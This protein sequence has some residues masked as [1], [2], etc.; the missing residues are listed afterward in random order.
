MVHFSAPRAAAVTRLNSPNSPN[1]S[2]TPSTSDRPD[3]PAPSAPKPVGIESDRPSTEQQAIR[4][5]LEGLVQGLGVR[6]AV[7]RLAHEQ[8]LTGCV[9]NDPR[10]VVVDV[11]GATS[12]VSRF[13]AELQDRL[14][15][16]VR[17]DRLQ[18]TPR[19]WVGYTSFQ[20]EDSGAMDRLATQVPPDRNVCT[21]C[22]AEVRTPGDRRFRYAFNSC[23]DCGP[24][25]SIIR[26]MPYERGDTSMADFEMCEACRHEYEQPSSRRFHAQTI[27]CGDCGPQ[28][29]FSTPPRDPDHRD[30]V[31][32]DELSFCLSP[33]PRV[34]EVA[35]SAAVKLIG[36]G[37]IV[38]VK[39]VGGYQLVCDASDEAAVER[40]RRR[41][42]RLAKPLAV[43]VSGLQQAT[44]LA[45]CNALERDALSSPAG[46]IVLVREQQGNG[47]ARGVN[48]G[49][50]EVGIMLPT[51]SL[52]Q[53][54]LDEVGKPLVVTSGNVDGEPL[55]DHTDQAEHRLEQIAD[56]F[57]HH[58]RIV[59][60]PIDDSVVRL[61]AGRRV[62]LRAGRGIAPLALPV[63]AGPAR[64]AVGG[65]Q[66]VAVA[67]SNGDQALLGPHIGDLDTVAARERFIE[68]VA[69]IGGLV[70]CHP[71]QIVVDTHPDS[72][73]GH[74][75]SEQS[76]SV[77]RVQHHHAH[78]VS[79]M[80]EA[81]WTEREVLGFAFDGTG[82]GTDGT[83][84]GGE[85]LRATV[86]RAD[87]VGHLLPIPLLGGDAAVRAPWRIAA[88]MLELACGDRSAAIV[89]ELKWDLQAWELL[90]P[91]LGRPQFAPQASSIGRL[92]DGVAAIALGI[93]ESDFGGQSAIRLEAAC[94]T[95]FS[96]TY[97]LT[98]L[99]GEPLRFDWRPLIG[100]LV[101]DRLAG[102]AAG[103]MA[104]RFH[105]GLANLIASIA[106]RMPSL[107]VVLAGGV[108]QNR[109][110]TELVVE[111]LAQH[112]APIGLPGNIP[113]GDGGLA[114]G[115]LL[116]GNRSV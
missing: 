111:G 85:V 55:V 21:A 80:V 64:I 110:L 4:I 90:R 39:G 41:K 53:L 76:A 99:E 14:P 108:F 6:P 88:A 29:W 35:L 69:S 12:A 103:Q 105:R 1:S 113:P 72:F 116:I 17:L 37:G 54:L 83:I 19:D 62:T 102:A 33:L 45:H 86:E 66:K 93:T 47:L 32:H 79:G 75:S 84:W 70:G 87:R 67:T 31:P 89:S 48:P 44:C 65:L 91:L 18:Q 42:G 22:L 11:E 59:E 23:L 94:D 68:S 97:Q 13:V 51:T 71:Q 36:V 43:M 104:I 95:R 77:L 61:I 96:G 5:T 82:W 30:I 100:Q 27:A 98:I 20:I 34:A 114:V 73:S 38:A 101:H 92:F 50:C 52:H 25:Y 24:R 115:Q 57:L 40:L 60:R 9:R 8:G 28:L 107:P 3:R 63:P 109:V 2:N 10:G 15:A 74:W 7:A 81:G 106:T 78:I 56:G 49:L 16:G 112:P 58:N 46:P 26:R